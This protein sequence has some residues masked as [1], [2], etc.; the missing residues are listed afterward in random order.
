MKPMST[1]Q[2]VSEAL[3]ALRKSQSLCLPGTVNRLMSALIR[4]GVAR[5]MM[6][7]MMEQTLAKRAPA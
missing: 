6:G 3:R 4:P 7:K 2:C 5:S 1:R